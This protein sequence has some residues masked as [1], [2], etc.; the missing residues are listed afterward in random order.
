MLRAQFLE[1]QQAMQVQM[2]QQMQQQL[3]AALKAAGINQQP[4]AAQVDFE[5][6]YNPETEERVSA[7]K[8]KV[9]AVNAAALNATKGSK[10]VLNKFS[11][12]RSTNEAELKTNQHM[13]NDLKNETEAT[14]APLVPN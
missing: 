1:T 12:S 2:Q 3:A 10:G 9:A 7:A 4:T 14:A 6:Q 11:K 5:F 13:A 8:A